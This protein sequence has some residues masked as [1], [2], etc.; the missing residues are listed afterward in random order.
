MEIYDEFLRIAIRLYSEYM[1]TLRAT[2]GST[3]ILSQKI[4][5]DGYHQRKLSWPNILFLSLIYLINSTKYKSF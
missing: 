1:N 5:S 3:G 2:F 4:S